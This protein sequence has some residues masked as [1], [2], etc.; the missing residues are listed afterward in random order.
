MLRKV[1]VR[2]LIASGTWLATTAAATA[3]VWAA[4]SVVVAD[5][6]DRPAA[7][8]PHREVVIALQTGSP[9]ADTAPAVTV[10]PTPTTTVPRPAPDQDRPAQPLIPDSGPT[11]VPPPTV[12]P[13]PPTPPPTNPPPVNPAA[14]AQPSPNPVAT[15][16]TAGGTV[17]VACSGYFIRL[18]SA[19]PTDGYAVDVL[20]RGPATVDVHFTGRGQE[21]QVRVVCLGGGPIRIPDQHRAPTT[22][23]PSRTGSR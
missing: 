3:L 1:Q 15:Y 7:V 6:T 2:R 11:S 10:A 14:P 16:S 19:T 12:P 20:D 9:A 17:T 22:T 18:I 23:V 8:L 5:V 4:T 13:P 21:I